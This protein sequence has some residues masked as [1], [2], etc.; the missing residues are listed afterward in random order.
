M[1]KVLLAGNSITADILYSYLKK[2]KR[3]EV[4]ATTVD[5]EYVDSNSINGLRS[6]AISQLNT[7]FSPDDVT[8]I[9]AMGYSNLNSNR[10]SMFLRL[11]EL[12]YTVETYIH[13]DACVYTEKF[14]GEGCV[15][16]PNAVVEPHVQVDENSIIWC[17]VILAHHCHIAKHC[18]IA[19]SAVISGQAS[20]S[21]NS[22]I[23]VNSTIVNKV[24]VGE[25]NV[26][27]AAAMISKNTKPN[28]VH[29]ARS[30]EQLRYSSDEYVKFFGV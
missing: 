25:F 15:V 22:F 8:V 2:D 29:L 28:T 10:E 18:W 23:G 6:V 17:N 26:I 19:S 20:I 13:E 30:A 24:L 7:F 12:G 21:R 5:D 14:L 27:G 11:K 9:M 4:M 1:K 3:Y 16:L